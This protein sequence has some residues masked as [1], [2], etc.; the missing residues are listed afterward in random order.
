MA[1]SVS[2]V[3]VALGAMTGIDP[4]DAAT[5]KSEGKFS[6]DY[7]KDLKIDALKGALSRGLASVPVRLLVGRPHPGHR[8]FDLRDIPRDAAAVARGSCRSAGGRRT[9]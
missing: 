6:T 9:G 8:P 3:A 2:D 5:Q 7:T 1:R 4:A